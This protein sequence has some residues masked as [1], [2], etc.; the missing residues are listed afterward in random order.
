[1][2]EL[3]ACKSLAI[4]QLRCQLLF[5]IGTPL[6]LLEIT[7]ITAVV[8]GIAIGHQMSVKGNLSQL[9]DGPA[10]FLKCLRLAEFRRLE[11]SAMVWGENG[12]DGDASE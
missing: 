1:M 7:G 10:S 8:Q 9:F 5:G 2:V 3:R 6:N 11:A 4:Q 12:C